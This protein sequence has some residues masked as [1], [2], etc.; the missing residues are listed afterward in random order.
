M[1][2][3]DTIQT[4][5]EQLTD[6]F[7]AEMPDVTISEKSE[8]GKRDEKPEAVTEFSAQRDAAG[9]LFDNKIHKVEEDGKPTIRSNNFVRLS[10][11]RPRKTEIAARDFAPDNSPKSTAGELFPNVAEKNPKNKKAVTPETDYSLVADMYIESVMAITSGFLGEEIKPENEEERNM[12]KIPLVK[13]LEEKGEIPFTP[14]QLLLL[15][16]VAYISK[17]SEKQTVRERAGLLMLRVKKFFGVKI[18]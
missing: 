2:T 1:K 8:G 3:E 13:V 18:Y 12:L 16:I 6:F 4:T 10:K 11:G 14:T 7:A 17:K 15:S 5:A 9:T